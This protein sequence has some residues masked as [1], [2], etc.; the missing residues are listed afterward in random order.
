MGC[1][2]IWQTRCKL[3]LHEINIRTYVNVPIERGVADEDGGALVNT[4]LSRRKALAHHVVEAPHHPGIRSG[5]ER[6]NL[7]GLFLH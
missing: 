5:V 2:I 4:N 7:E 6:V 1:K 3:H